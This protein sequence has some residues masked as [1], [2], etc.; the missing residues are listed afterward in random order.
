MADPG[1][2]VT[3]L[4]S[5]VHRGLYRAS[6]GRVGGGMRGAPILLLTTVGHRSGKRRTTPLI[7]VRDGYDFVVAASNQGR[8]FHPGWWQNLQ[9]DPSA[10]VQARRERVAVLAAEVP[11]GPERERLRAALVALYAG[12]ADYKGR[13]QR[14]IPV[15][16]LTRS[17]EPTRDRT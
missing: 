6:G 2:V 5:A 17:A 16:R 12:F 4:I 11:A 8:D 14:A 3:R 9:A 10:A 1:Y 7:Y 15:V 13:T